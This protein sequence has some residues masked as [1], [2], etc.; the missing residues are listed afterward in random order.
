MSE[1]KEHQKFMRLAIKLAD[2]NV[3][4]NIGG[5]FGAVIV[6]KGKVIAKSA[7]KVTL[8]ND[9]TAHAEV[10]AI[11]IACKKLKTFDLQGCIIYTS[12]EPC[13]MCLSAIYWSHLDEIYYANTKEDAARIG[14][15]DQFIYEEIA[16]P[17]EKRKVPIKQMLRNEAINSFN[18]W[19]SSEMK[20]EY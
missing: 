11:R 19:D 13:P 2:K 3:Q 7:N 18:L 12:C 9:P 17:Y 4:K 8:K 20:I 15:D 6:K 10:S 14:F 5:P 16:L 1:N